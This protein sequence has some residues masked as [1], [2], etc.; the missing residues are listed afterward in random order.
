MGFGY[1]E[2][3]KSVLKKKCAIVFAHEWVVGREHPATFENRLR[4]KAKSVDIRCSAAIVVQ[5]GLLL[6]YH[7]HDTI[8]TQRLDASDDQIYCCSV[9]V[10]KTFRIVRC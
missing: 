3:A 5:V 10:S 7:H 2:T 1:L 6:S 9:S 8:T 4:A